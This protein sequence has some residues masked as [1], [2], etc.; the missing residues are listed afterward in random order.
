MGEAKDPYDGILWNTVLH[1]DNTTVSSSKFCVL[2]YLP[3]EVA[4][5]YT[6]YFGVES[7]TEQITTMVSSNF[8]LLGAYRNRRTLTA[9]VT[10]I[11]NYWRISM[12]QAEI[13]NCW[14]KDP[15]GSYIFKG[16]NVGGVILDY[17][18]LSGYSAERSAA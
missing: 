18:Q 14:V 4:G 12:I 5:N 9:T 10:Q 7:D 8:T 11:G 2:P 13:D 17:Q 3:I 1:P 15:N 6:L 16:R